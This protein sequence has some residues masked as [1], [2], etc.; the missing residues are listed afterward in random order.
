MDDPAS[1]LPVKLSCSPAPVH[2][3]LC[4]TQRPAPCGLTLH[5]LS[6]F[7]DPWEATSLLPRGRP[8]PGQDWG[9]PAFRGLARGGLRAS[10][11]VNRGV[12]WRL[13]PR[14]WTPNGVAFAILS[15]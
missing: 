5:G 12:L 10:G 14:T 7:Q 2:P 13:R 3:E 15:K 11:R 1:T 9:L 8:R 6:P 4:D